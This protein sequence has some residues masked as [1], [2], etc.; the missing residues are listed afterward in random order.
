[1]ENTI[2]TQSTYWSRIN[3]AQLLEAGGLVTLFTCASLIYYFTIFPDHNWG[4]DFAQYLHQAINITQGQAMDDT[5]YI[6]SRYTP[7]LGPRA[8]PPGFPLLLAPVYALFGLNITAFQIEIILFQLLAFIVI[9][10][11]YRR[12]VAVP[13]ALML[14]MM[15][16]FSPYIISFKRQIMSDVPFMLVSLTFVLWI[17]HAYQHQKFGKWSIVAAALLAFACYLIRTIGFVVIIA[18]IVS[19]LIRRRRLT[20]FS[21]TTT[22]VAVGLVLVS[23]LLLGGGEES[24]LD[25]LADYSPMILVNG[26]EHYLI[27]SIRGFWAGPSIN[28]GEYNFPFLWLAAIPLIIFGF[29]LRA[30]RSTLFLELFFLFHLFIILAWPS[31]QELRFLYPI[32]PL[33]LLYAGI[34]FEHCLY[35]LMKHFNPKLAYTAAVL[36]ASGLL[37]IYAVRTQKVI[38]SETL[39][40]DGPYTST[41]VEMFDFV[42]TQTD[43]ASVFIFVKPRVLALYTN[44]MAST[45]PYGQSSAVAAAYLQEIHADYLVIKNTDVDHVN[46]SIFSLLESCQTAFH[47]VFHNN[48]FEIYRIHPDLCVISD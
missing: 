39:Y 7:S 29:I 10:L 48:D 22:L 14:L 26:T 23:R 43:P 6:Y 21:I 40:P 47:S 16:A 37:V 38:A 24:Y 18:L 12:E 5:G 15:M 36:A 28:I 8:Y 17:E 44:R 45:Y 4:G 20:R 34:G 30:K 11:I 19:D 9:Y 33:F 27:H 25:Q 2:P 41:A 35:W 32:L 3:L 1:M 13:T 46:P 31:V 42:Q